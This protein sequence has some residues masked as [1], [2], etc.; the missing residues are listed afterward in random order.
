MQWGD[1]AK[2][3][4]RSGYFFSKNISSL[5]WWG[6]APSG[7]P[8][9]GFDIIIYD[10]VGGVVANGPDLTSEAFRYND[11]MPNQSVVGAWSTYDLYYYSLEFDPCV[12]WGSNQFLSIQSNADTVTWYW[13]DT[14]TGNGAFAWGIDTQ[15]SPDPE[16]GEP[17][18][19][20]EPGRIPPRDL[21]HLVDN[22]LAFG[23]VVHVLHT[24][25]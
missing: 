21:D 22:G 14:A 15:V 11:V 2:G 9:A 1:C 10:A 24:L 12:I 18:G 19:W 17:F 20:P 23:S 6:L 5:H 3:V 4:W 7:H 8:T 13:C 16:I 25:E